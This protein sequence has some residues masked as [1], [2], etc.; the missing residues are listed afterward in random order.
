MNDIKNLVEKLERYVSSL[1]G[2]QWKLCPSGLVRTESGN[3]HFVAAAGGFDCH[4]VASRAAL[5]AACSPANMRMVL[6]YIDA[7][8]N[9]E[10]DEEAFQSAKREHSEQFIMGQKDPLRAAI[11]AYLEAC[12]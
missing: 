4:G 12:K 8:Q 7:T 9:K 2:E 6:N 3:Q 10:F 1:E 11:E 5:I